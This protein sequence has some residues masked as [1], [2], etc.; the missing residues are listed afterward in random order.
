MCYCLLIFLA[1]SEGEHEGHVRLVDRDGE[2]VQV[3]ARPP[4]AEL[5]KQ[6]DGEHHQRRLRDSLENTGPE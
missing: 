2:V 3:P 5:G 1:R 4:H 6:S